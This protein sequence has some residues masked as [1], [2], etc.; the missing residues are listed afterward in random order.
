VITIKQPG[1]IPS[2]HPPEALVAMRIWQP[3]AFIKRAVK[4]NR[5]MFLPSYAWDRPAKQKI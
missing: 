5:Y 1:T 4:V 3:R 2:P